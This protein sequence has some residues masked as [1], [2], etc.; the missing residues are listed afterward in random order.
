MLQ[1]VGLLS[2]CN[3]Q[4]LP[5]A[6]EMYKRDDEYGYQMSLTFKKTFSIPVNIDFLGVWLVVV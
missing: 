1:K 6:Y 3:Y 5:F 4:Q 2:A